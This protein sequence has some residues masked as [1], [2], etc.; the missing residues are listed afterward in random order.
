MR[1][2]TLEVFEDYGISY[3]AF[4]LVT[5]GWAV[6]FKQAQNLEGKMGLIAAIELATRTSGTICCWRIEDRILYDVVQILDSEN[7]ATF[8]AKL[9]KQTFIYHIE[10][11]QL[12]WIA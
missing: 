5:K 12:K 4:E 1:E 8:F 10:T 11:G 6:N 9:A 7:E 2:H 3:V